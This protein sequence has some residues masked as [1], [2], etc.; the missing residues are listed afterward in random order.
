MSRLAQRG[1][2][3]AAT[4]AAVFF[5]AVWIGDARKLQRAE[6]LGN[7][8]AATRAQVEHTLSL[9]RGS[10]RLRPGAEPH[11]FAAGALARLGRLDAAMGEARDVVRGEPANVTGWFVLAGLA[12]GRDPGAFRQALDR[13][14][15]LRPLGPQ[16]IR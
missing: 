2:M 1:A 5:V 12:R 8:P 9:A 6:E 3:I 4:A 7:S 14:H 16:P 13:L 10:E 15:E 11:L